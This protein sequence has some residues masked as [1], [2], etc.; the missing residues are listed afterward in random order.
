MGCVAAPVHSHEGQV[1]AALNVG[2]PAERINESFDHILEQVIAHAAAI[3][4][5]LGYQRP[6]A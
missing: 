5:K 4:E 6:Q 2:G 1:I 3:S